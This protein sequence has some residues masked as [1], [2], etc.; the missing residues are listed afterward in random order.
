MDIIPVIDLLGGAV[1]HAIAGDRQRYRAIESPLAASARPLDVAAGLLE[2]WP[3]STL[4]I[5]DLDHMA[6]GGSNSNGAVVAELAAA[7]SA[8]D[9]WVDTGAR[10]LAD[11]QALLANSRVLP[12]VGSETGITAAE[13]QQL[14]AVFGDQFVLSLDYRSDGFWGDPSLIEAA[15]IWPERVIVMTLSKVGT[16][17]GPDV[18]LVHSIAMRHGARCGETNCG[19]GQVYAAGGIRTSNDLTVLQQAGAHGALIATALHAK[20]ITADDLREIAGRVG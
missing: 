16:A 4:Y 17:A 5:A 12:V 13:V 7:H 2:L 1:V 3:F 9:L 6:S 11:L 18:A 14:L 10:S 20:T 15:A 19:R 8:T